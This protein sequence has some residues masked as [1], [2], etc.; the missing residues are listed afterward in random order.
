MDRMLSLKKPDLIACWLLYFIHYQG[1]Q[2]L[3][4]Q[5]DN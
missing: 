4:K 5:Q 1:I 2:N 3:K